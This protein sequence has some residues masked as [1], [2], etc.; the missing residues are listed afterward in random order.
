M[1]KAIFLDRDG[2]INVE[3]NYLHKIDE[4]E[5]IPGTVESLKLLQKAGYKLIVI[6]NQ[7][8]IARGLYAEKEFLNLNDWM[9]SEI[10]KSGVIVDKVYYCPHHPEAKIKEYRIDCNCRK[11]KLGLFEKAIDEF[12]L[13]LSGCYAI[14]DKIRDCSICMISECKGFLIGNNEKQEIIEQVKNGKYDNIDYADNLYGAVLK[15]TEAKR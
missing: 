10:E 5:F 1:N 9:L 3:K 12:N 15:I 2:T 7:S 13:D 14:G 6:T 8:G 4:F 11:P